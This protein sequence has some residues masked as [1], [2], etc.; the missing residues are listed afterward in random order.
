MK[1]RRH[2]RMQ[3]TT[4]TRFDSFLCSFFR[5]SPFISTVQMKFELESRNEQA[6]GKTKRRKW[7]Q[8]A[9]QKELKK[10]TQQQQRDKKTTRQWTKPEQE[11][12][13]KFEYSQKQTHTHTNTPVG[14][15]ESLCFGRIMKRTR[16]KVKNV[17]K[18]KIVKL[19]R[20]TTS[21][22]VRNIRSYTQQQQ[23][24]FNQ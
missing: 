6:H 8:V 18:W 16:K 9:A 24:Q 13:H 17:G 11:K 7:M 22:K 19:V 12:K 4:C 20:N 3:L 14:R 5:T 15:I 23:H 21:K 10:H 1:Q 2:Y